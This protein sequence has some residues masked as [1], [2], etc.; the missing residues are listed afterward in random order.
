[1]VNILLDDPSIENVRSLVEMWGLVESK[2]RAAGF[3]LGLAVSFTTGA[4][5]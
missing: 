4:D 3:Q 2:R 5:L 1:M